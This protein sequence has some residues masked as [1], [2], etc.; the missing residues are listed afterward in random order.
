MTGWTPERLR[1]AFDEAA[2]PPD[3]G[4]AADE[5]RIVRP[6]GA[7]LATVDARAHPAGDRVRLAARLAAAAAESEGRRVLLTNGALDVPV[8]PGDCPC[9]LANRLIRG[10]FEGHR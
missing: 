7:L 1:A 2:A 10:D 6:T 8:W 5:L 9:D 4:T 3:R